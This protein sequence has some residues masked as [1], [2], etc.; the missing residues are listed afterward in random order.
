MVL[1]ILGKDSSG[2]VWFLLFRCVGGRGLGRPKR[3]TPASQASES[4]PPLV[5]VFAHVLLDSNFGY[6]RHEAP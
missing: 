3:H 6:K 1:N 2:V 5:V 4:L